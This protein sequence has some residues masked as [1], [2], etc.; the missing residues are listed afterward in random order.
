MIINSAAS[1]DD[2]RVR[3]KERRATMG[4]TN[5]LIAWHL[6]SLPSTPTISTIHHR[7]Q[8][9]KPIT[10]SVRSINMYISKLCVYY[11]S[12]ETDG[13][14]D[15]ASSKTL[16]MQIQ[17]TYIQF[18]GSKMSLM[19]RCKL[20]SEIN[21]PSTRIYYQYLCMLVDHYYICIYQTIKSLYMRFIY[22]S[23]YT[24][25]CTGL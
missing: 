6:A 12:T 20:L 22:W 23:G 11:S 14:T 13:Q 21:M 17:Y 3:E 18:M 24:K 9:D 10:N 15:L 4:Q 25:K 7:K 19:V 16:L 1:S 8:C 2:R 5:Q